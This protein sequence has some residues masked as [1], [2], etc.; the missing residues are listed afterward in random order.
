VNPRQIK[1]LT[2]C[3]PRYQAILTKAFDVKAS[4]RAA[5]RAFCLHCV[6]YSLETAVNCTSYGCPLFGYRPGQKSASAGQ[7]RGQ[8][9]KTGDS[10]ETDEGLPQ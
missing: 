6:G 9:G 1:L 2:E 4:P 8:F 5:I 7:N 10:E 3:P